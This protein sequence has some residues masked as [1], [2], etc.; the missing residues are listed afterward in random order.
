MAAAGA[1]GDRRRRRG[2]RMRGC[3]QDDTEG[4]R[5][6]RG[7]L[8]IPWHHLRPGCTHRLAAGRRRAVEGRPHLQPQLSGPR[9][10]AT[11]PSREKQERDQRSADARSGRRGGASICPDSRLLSSPLNGRPRPSFGQRPVPAA[12]TCGS[13]PQIAAIPGSVPRARRRQKGLGQAINAALDA[14]L[15]R[16]LLYPAELPGRGLIMA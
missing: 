12:Q 1:A 13:P 3:A 11:P 8:C 6:G 5:W 4:R 10:R 16:Q 9:S 15:R 2:R 14:A 7:Q